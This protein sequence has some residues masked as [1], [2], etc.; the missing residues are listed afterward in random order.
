MKSSLSSKRSKS[1]SSFSNPILMSSIRFP[2]V[3][4]GVGAL[5]SEGGVVTGVF[6]GLTVFK[7]FEYPFRVSTC[8]VRKRLLL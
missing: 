2:T 3:G 8:H 7:D 4:W 1:S 5:G 6:A